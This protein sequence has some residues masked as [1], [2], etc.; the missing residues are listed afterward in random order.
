MSWDQYAEAMA[1][2]FDKPVA[3]EILT[4]DMLDPAD[5]ARHFLAKSGG[6][7]RAASLLKTLVE[8]RA[9]CDKIKPEDHEKARLFAQAR[10]DFVRAE[11][12]LRAALTEY[13]RNPPPPAAEAPPA[14]QTVQPVF[15]IEVAAPVVNLE[16]QIP[17]AQQVEIVSMPTR[18]TV[19]EVRRDRAGKI[20]ESTQIE[21]DAQ[22]AV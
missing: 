10:A 6:L 7:E 19:T 9:E 14:T 18:E 1:A 3:Q 8:L 15:H 13:Y 21:R 4:L 12:R 16:A 2:N 5:Y 20:T 11:A 22:E 17:A